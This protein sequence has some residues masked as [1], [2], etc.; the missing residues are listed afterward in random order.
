MA[1]RFLM[2]AIG[3]GVLLS[4]PAAAGPAGSVPSFAAGTALRGTSLLTIS[5]PNSFALPVRLVGIMSATL[6][7]EPISK[8]LAAV[9]LL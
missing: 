9:D 2:F 7:L 4:G 1:C 8:L 6:F 3:E 5:L